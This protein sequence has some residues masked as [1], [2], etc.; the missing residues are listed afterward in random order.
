MAWQHKDGEIYIDNIPQAEVRQL[1]EEELE[2]YA[3]KEWKEQGVKHSDDPSEAKKLK[4]LTGPKTEEGRKKALKNLRPIKSKKA[5][6]NP[7]YKKVPG[8]THGGTVKALLNEEEKE[9]FEQRVKSYLEDFDVNDSSDNVLLTMTV[10]EEIIWR[11]LLLYQFQNPK[12]NVDKQISESQNRLRN[13]L[14]TLGM[15]RE[16]RQGLKINV[17]TSISDLATRFVK[18]IELLEEQSVDYK[19]EEEEVLRRQREREEDSGSTEANTYD[20]P[21]SPEKFSGGGED[22]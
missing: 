11:R 2:E 6:P 1:T 21:S 3:S 5:A 14:K 18:E 9:I 10:M 16:Q 8:M 13:N 15:T 19:E 22:E 20:Y 17:E 7:A 4:N 12:M